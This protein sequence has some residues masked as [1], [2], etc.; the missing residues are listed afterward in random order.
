MEEAS[1]TQGLLHTEQSGTK[2]KSVRNIFWLASIKRRKTAEEVIH[3]QQS[4]PELHYSLQ[5]QP[6]AVQQAM[7]RRGRGRPPCDITYGEYPILPGT[8]LLSFQSFVLCSAVCNAAQ[9]RNIA[10]R[11]VHSFILFEH[12]SFEAGHFFRPA[13][14]PRALSLSLAGN[15]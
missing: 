7:G 12:R 11:V 9:A 2:E 13:A 8:P 6:W 4:I 15:A 1:F 5:K 10:S 3:M 14:L